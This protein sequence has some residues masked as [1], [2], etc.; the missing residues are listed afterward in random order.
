[1]IIFLLATAQFVRQTL[2]KSLVTLYVTQPIKHKKI[3]H[4]S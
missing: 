2:D 1:M 3:N 4:N